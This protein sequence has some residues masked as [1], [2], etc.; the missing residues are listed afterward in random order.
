[1]NINFGIHS[2]IMCKAGP[3]QLMERNFLSVDMQ[4]RLCEKLDS[5]NQN[6]YKGLEDYVV[7]FRKVMS[8]V[9]DMSDLDRAMSFTRG[10]VQLTRQKVLYRRCQMMTVAIAVVLEFERSHPSQFNMTYQNKSYSRPHTSM[11]TQRQ[12][13]LDGAVRIDNILW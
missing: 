10:V 6:N 5:L 2:Q 9:K 3:L 1:M 4:E 12:S 11:H 8:E 7:K 13:S